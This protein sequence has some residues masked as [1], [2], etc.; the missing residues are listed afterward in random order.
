MI[1]GQSKIAENTLGLEL[2]ATPLGDH[3]MK[4]IV[5]VDAFLPKA[6]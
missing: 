2:Q 4:C 1:T 5:P 6:I 3:V